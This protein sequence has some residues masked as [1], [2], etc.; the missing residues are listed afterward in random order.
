MKGGQRL[1]PST[2]QAVGKQSAHYKYISRVNAREE[3]S[4]F[5]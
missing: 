2:A 1:V 3:Q 4:Y 5:S